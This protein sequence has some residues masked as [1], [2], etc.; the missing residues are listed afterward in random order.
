MTNGCF[1][2][3]G[4]VGVISKPISVSLGKAKADFS[5][6]VNIS[7]ELIVVDLIKIPL[8]HIFLQQQVIKIIVRGQIELLENPAELIL[9]DVSNLSNVE[10]FKLWLQMQSFGGD[11]RLESS[12]QLL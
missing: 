3:S 2:L 6:S 4:L 5:I 12:Q 11:Y 1:R 10:V 9:S 7:D 8:V